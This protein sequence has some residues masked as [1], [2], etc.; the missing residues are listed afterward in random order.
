MTT[1][2]KIESK[3]DVCVAVKY[4]N[5]YDE[6][7]NKEYINMHGLAHNNY[8]VNVF[9]L[10]ITSTD[11]NFFR[12]IFDSTPKSNIKETRRHFWN[13][14]SKMH[15]IWIVSGYSGTSRT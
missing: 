6:R 9:G 7:N 5:N 8:I 14:E 1:K 13:P 15:G 12:K 10:S 4:I 3:G 11:S 2:E